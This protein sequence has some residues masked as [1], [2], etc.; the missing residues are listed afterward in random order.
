MGRDPGRVLLMGWRALLLGLLLTAALTAA[1]AVPATADDATP[2]P[3]PTLAPTPSISPPSQQQIDDARS[4]LDRLRNPGKATPSTLTQVAGPIAEKE[5]G[6][7][8][9]RISDEAWWT[10]GAG[11]LVLAVASETT[12]LS[13]RRAKHRRKA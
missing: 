10:I 11:A 2:A 1:A 13:V 12:R 9:S 6:S 5:R 8:T 3:A 7:V 4:A